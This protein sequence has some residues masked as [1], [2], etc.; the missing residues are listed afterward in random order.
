MAANFNARRTVE[1]MVIP[2]AFVA[3]V[4]TGFDDEFKEERDAM[5]KLFDQAAQ[6]VLPSALLPKDAGSLFRRT[7]DVILNG[8]TSPLKNESYPS[9]KAAL[10][11]YYFLT[12]MIDQ[13]LYV[14]ADGS[15]FR[16]AL[17]LFLPTVQP[18][19]EETRF[20]KSAFKEARKMLDRMHG[21][22]YYTDV[23]WKATFE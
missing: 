1:A 21:L 14:I 18:W 2:L 23:Q 15:T 3:V 9:A 5:A 13:G 19:V 11:L 10:I 7:K 17:D 4:K 12:N 16:K 22:G 6:E 20:D 8:I